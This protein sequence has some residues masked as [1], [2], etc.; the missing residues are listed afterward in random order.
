MNALRKFIK[1][2]VFL[3][4]NGSMG[5]ATLRSRTDAGD[6]AIDP[7]LSVMRRGDTLTDDCAR[8]DKSLKV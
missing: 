5:S 8:T 7:A 1:A 6:Q 4:S 3:L 2:S